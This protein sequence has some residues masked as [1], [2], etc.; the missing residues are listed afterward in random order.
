VVVLKGADLALT[1]YPSFALRPMCDLDLLVH[2]GSMEEGLRRLGRLGYRKAMPEVASGHDRITGHATCLYGGAHDCVTVELHWGLVAG[3]H[4]WRSPNLDWFWK[5]AE[6][7]KREGFG[8]ISIGSEAGSETEL[9][10]SFFHLK[11]TAHMLYLAAHLMF[12]HGGTRLLWYY[13]LHLLVS[14]YRDQMDWEEILRWARQFRWTAPLHAALKGVRDRFQTPLPD[15]FLDDLAKEP[16]PQA[17]SLLKHLSES[18]RPRGERIWNEMMR[19]SWRARLCFAWNHFFP[20]R[21]Y[22]SWRYKPRPDWL[23]PLCYPYRWGVIFAGG[24][25]AMSRW[26]RRLIAREENP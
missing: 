5:Q 17:Q 18:A 6:E 20:S 13:D 21:A 26:A 3:D 11:P 14:R 15:G 19:L 16:D 25:S 23:W 7:W 8:C 9:P 2:R 22:V 12:Q 4:D 24:L 10:A 1:V